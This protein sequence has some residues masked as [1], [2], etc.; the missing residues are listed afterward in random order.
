VRVQIQADTTVTSF[1]SV[2]MGDASALTVRPPRSPKRPHDRPPLSRLRPPERVPTMPTGPRN[3][4]R[5]PRTC[6]PGPEPAGRRHC[7]P[8]P[9]K[10]DF[11]RVSL[12]TGGDGF[13]V[14]GAVRRTPRRWRDATRTSSTSCAPPGGGTRALSAPTWT[15]T[16]RW[17]TVSQ[18]RAAH[19]VAVIGR[20]SGCVHRIKP[21]QPRHTWPYRAAGTSGTWYDR[22]LAVFLLKSPYGSWIAT[23]R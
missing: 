12:D 3:V 1:T 9:R 7:Q 17:L 6:R 19:P 14:S 22:L 2:R 16:R 20:V 15:R 10:S 23:A 5:P 11:Q 8:T 4:P 21:P 13:R 18:G